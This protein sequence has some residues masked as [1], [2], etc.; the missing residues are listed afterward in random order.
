MDREATVSLI[1]GKYT[2]R[3]EKGMEFGYA[4]KS[5][6][7]GSE[8]A[9]GDV[10]VPRF[11]DMN[12]AGWYSGDLHIHRA[13]E[14]MPLLVLAEEFNIA[15][16]ITRHVGGTRGPPPYT[17]VHLKPVD[18]MHIV[19]LQDQEVERLFKGH[20]AV[21]LLNTPEAVEDKLAD[22]YPMDIEFCR[23][24]RRQ[25]GFVEGEKPIWK[26]VSVT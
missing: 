23:S 20:G 19:S 15:P 16:D 5:I 7:F 3:A 8:P 21:D 12:A 13:P 18:A 24:A 10:D 4:Q 25:G 2:V 11:F 17:A 14:E 9:R 1:P 6:Q 26:N 22:L